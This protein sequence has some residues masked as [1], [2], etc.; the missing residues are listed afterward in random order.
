MNENKRFTV[1]DRYQFS[2]SKVQLNGEPLT[3]DEIVRILNTNDGAFLENFYLKKENKELKKEL[4]EFEN[5][6]F[7]DEN[8]LCYSCVNCVSKGIYEVECSEKGKVDVHGTCFLYWKNEV[9]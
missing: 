3:N 1:P 8:I 5:Y 2:H 9:E 4:Q 7:S 6:V